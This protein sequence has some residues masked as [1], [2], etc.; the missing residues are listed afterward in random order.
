MSSNPQDAQELSNDALN[1]HA[2]ARVRQCVTFLASLGI[3]TP[4]QGACC[5]IRARSLEELSQALA[6]I[7]AENIDILEQNEL[8]FLRDL[9]GM[10]RC[11]AQGRFLDL[12]GIWFPVSQGH[13][14]KLLGTASCRDDHELPG[15]RQAAVQWLLCAFDRCVRRAL[16]AGMVALVVNVESCR[17]LSTQVLAVA[18]PFDHACIQP[19]LSSATCEIHSCQKAVSPSEAQIMRGVRHHYELP[20]PAMEE[21]IPLTFDCQEAPNRI[22]QQAVH[23][24]ERDAHNPTASSEDSVSS[25][26]KSQNTL[27]SRSSARLRSRPTAHLCD[28]ADLR[29]EANQVRPGLRPALGGRPPTKAEQVSS[30]TQPGT[31][32]RMSLKQPRPSSELTHARF[33]AALWNEP[34]WK[35]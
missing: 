28:S 2:K 19:L 22:G 27:S 8:G 25:S 21:L 7:L 26:S 16:K 6:P 11:E 3:V 15:M 9:H 4:P 30:L 13:D 14:Q 17:E 34:K 5:A 12:G 24:L 32:R 31:K 23:L 35:R 18:S 29:T 33:T 1:D 20:L 10:W